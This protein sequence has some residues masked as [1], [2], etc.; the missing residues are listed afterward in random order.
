MSGWLALAGMIVA[1]APPAGTDETFER[2]VRPLLVER[3]IRC[4]GAEKASGGLRLDSRAA[5]LRGGDSGPAAVEGKPEESL[6]VR[7]VEQKDEL[8]MPPKGALAAAEVAT[9]RGWIARGLDWPSTGGEAMARAAE[10]ATSGATAARDWWSF[11]PVQDPP[12]PAV[13]DAAWP[14][15]EIDRFLLAK[16]ESRDLRP[17]PATDRRTLIRRATY[18]LTGLPPTPEEVD[19]FV[20]DDAPDAFAR[21]VDRLLASPAYG[22]RWGRHWLDLVRY[23]D[24]AGENSDHPTPHAWRYRNWVIDAFN[25]DLPYDE[26][27]R[28]QV[29]GDL[30]AAEGPAER[31][32][33]GVVATGFL[34]IARRFGHDI[35]QDV[36]L[37][38]EDVIDTMGKTFLGLTIA[39]ARCHDHK[40][41][42]IGTR[43]YYA[44]SGI[45]QSTRFSF[46][47]CEPK[48]QPRD[49]VPMQS[50]SD[51]DRT[52]RPHREALAAVEADMKRVADRVAAASRALFPPGVSEADLVARGS[53]PD[54]G[55]QAFGDS[56]AIKID[57]VEVEPGTVL[58]LVV[59]PI[60]NH[61]ADSTRVELEVAQAD[62]PGRWSLAADVLDDLL[63]G[64]PHADRLGHA[65]VW[66]FLDGRPGRGPLPEP[67]RDLDGKLGLNV[68]RD[69]E[70]PSVFVNARELPLPVWTTLPPR[71]VFVHPAPDGPVA[72]AW[73]S[74]IRGRVQIRGRIADAHPGGPDGVAWSIDRLDGDR[75]EALQCLAGLASRRTELARAKADLEAR[76]PKP[77]VAYAV[78]EGTET[79]SPIHLRGDPEKRGPVVARRWL[80]IL[81]GQAVTPGKGS[82]R[83]ELAGW[84]A[85]ASNPLAARVMVNRIWQQHFGRGIVGTPSD[86]GT[87]GMPPTHPELLDWLAS[88]F[89]R[90]GWSVKAMH[91]RIMLSSAYRQSS[92]ASRPAL[93]LDPENRLWGRFSRRRLSAEEIRD[94]LLVAGGSLDLTPGGPHPFPPESSWS[95]TQHNPFNTDYDTDRRSVYMVSLRNRRQP[96]LGLFDGAD[97]NA[98]T[99]ERQRT[100]VP[101]QALFFLNDP[102]FHRQAGRLADRAIAAGPDDAGRL[103]A[104]CR[105]ALQ[106]VPG[107]RDRATASAFLAR[108]AAELKDLPPAERT[109]EA[110]SAL[111]RAVLASNEFLYL[112]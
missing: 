10:P 63:A 21:L 72:V 27:V 37:T 35:D 18:D 62:G 64:N 60:G 48:Q 55:S 107:D 105:I 33:E 30:V 89:I 74:P 109:R 31:H 15:S 29:A 77:Q 90:D 66:W 26:F 101:T 95:F 99:P 13:R 34:A 4:H 16:L 59:A 96:F 82:G 79:D 88:R 108:Y 44:L 98:T 85:S 80:E 106:R 9:I 42:P 61:G 43:D 93:E 83:R 14:R 46:P 102:F 100:T 22:E 40:Y 32:A 45:L 49:L 19:A 47:G 24:T 112:D 91:R 1:A 75:R 57:P 86:F 28:L 8:R 94:S 23:A 3:C 78:A 20:R 73:V 65:G 5:I 58:R 53:I 97:P 51:W 110:W 69:G 7:A 6:I 36:H 67:V 84:L 104:L 71:S 39:C 68:W 52:I 111:A 76:A 17:A 56:S 41:D 81:G 25:R 70:T 92:L 87:R 12:P 2:S 11:R 54:G 38:H 50:A 103:D